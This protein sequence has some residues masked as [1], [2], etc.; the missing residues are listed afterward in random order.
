MTLE[1]TSNDTATTPAH[2][3][4]SPCPT[5]RA[6]FP[7]EEVDV[8]KEEVDVHEFKEFDNAT[9]QTLVELLHQQ[10]QELNKTIS[11]MELQ[12]RN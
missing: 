12:H 8:H 11:V 9:L 1:K 7:E 10:V 5:L 6:L 2:S 3:L 4:Q